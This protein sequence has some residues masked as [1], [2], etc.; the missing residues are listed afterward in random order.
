MAQA[1]HQGLTQVHANNQPFQ[2]E[3]PTP[4]E[5][6]GACRRNQECARNPIGWSQ[7]LNRGKDK[8]KLSQNEVVLFENEERELSRS[9]TFFMINKYGKQSRHRNNKGKRAT[10]VHRRSNT[11]EEEE[12]KGK[13]EQGPHLPIPSS[14]LMTT[15]YSRKGKLQFR[16]E[17]GPDDALTHHRPKELR[18]IRVVP[19][20]SKGRRRGKE[21][22]TIPL[23]QREDEE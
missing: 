4:M 6:I 9:E 2:E 7:N 13:V 12:R 11:R 10:R 22:N 23:D 14:F 18:Q 8:R 3:Q 16:K 17:T 15:S 5:R 20:R 1:K 19:K 21:E